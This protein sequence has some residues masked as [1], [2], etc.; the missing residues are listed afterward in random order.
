MNGI[1]SSSIVASDRELCASA[2][3]ELVVQ[4]ASL[5]FTVPLLPIAP[6]DKA[7]HPHTAVLIPAQVRLVGKTTYSNVGASSVTVYLDSRLRSDRPDTLR[8]SSMKILRQNTNAPHISL[9]MRSLL[10]GN[11][12]GDLAGFSA[13][14]R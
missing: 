9:S 4:Q 12:V 1:K 13:V 11:G 8:V 2:P 5:S 7:A 6:L 3:A 14:F 10:D